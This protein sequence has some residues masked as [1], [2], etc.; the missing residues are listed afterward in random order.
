MRFLNIANDMAM[1]EIDMPSVYVQK[2]FGRFPFARKREEACANE[3]SASNSIA[4]PRHSL[5]R[6]VSFLCGFNSND[7]SSGRFTSLCHY[8]IPEK[9]FCSVLGFLFLNTF[10]CKE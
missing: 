2:N 1:K 4:R 5:G 8:C 10:N 3:V 7:F 9:S 6:P